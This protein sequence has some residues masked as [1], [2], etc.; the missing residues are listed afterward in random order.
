LTTPHAPLA[1]PIREEVKPGL[2][3]RQLLVRGG[4][5]TG[6]L[7]VGAWVVRAASLFN[8]RPAGGRQV[9][10]SREVAI[11][12]SLIEAALPGDGD[13]PPGDVAFITAYVD[14]FLAHG[15]PDGRLLFKTVLQV[16]EE[17]SLLTRFSRFTSLSLASRID[18]IRAWELT[19]V[20]LKNAAF[21]SVK[22]VIGMGYF[23]QPSA[24]GPSPADAIGWY[25]GCAP[26]HMI[27]KS[28]DRFSSGTT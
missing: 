6:A 12:G 17:Q 22:L 10:S 1:T 18:E 9:L 20:Y 28:K 27:H 19:P 15:D 23:E 8:Q 3:R 13:M 11:L 7:I 2:T 24:R 14:D 26:P 5:T 16:M 4:L 25:V 21:Q